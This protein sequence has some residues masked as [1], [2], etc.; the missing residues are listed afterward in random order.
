MLDVLQSSYPNEQIYLSVDE[1]H[2]NEI[3]KKIQL[4]T[5]TIKHKIFKYNHKEESKKYALLKTIREVC[6]A[7]SLFKLAKADRAKLIF[8][9]S[10]YPF[11]AIFLN[12][13]ST[14]FKQQIIICQHGD[15]GVLLL[16][17]DKITTKVFRCV[18]KNVLR[19]RNFKY[20]ISLF[21]G[22]TIKNNLYSLYPQYPNKNIITI[23]HP[24]E[25]NIIAF[26]SMLTYPVVIANIGTAI[27][28]KNS[29]L[30]FNLAEQ[31]KEAIGQK[32]I[33]IIQVG[34]MSSEVLAYSNQYVECL[35]N[36]KDFIKPEIFNGQ[37]MEADYFIY[38]FEKGG[39]YDLCP[40][41]TF[42]DAIKYNKPIV[43]LH[44]D[45]FDYYFSK[46]GNIGYLCDTIE[47]I[48]DIITSISKGEKVN[49]Y[50]IQV[51]NINNAKD[52]LS[53][54]EIANSFKGQLESIIDNINL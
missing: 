7:W 54:K 6:L 32:K 41:G 42:F 46:F 21:Y 43:A 30:I 15:L 12:L 50:P 31:V 33:K 48:A 2:L 10:A 18:I 53:I 1:I 40:S 35:Y 29:Q 4:K 52:R 27:L 22:L 36:G 47:E 44:N 28:A 23:D 39:Y 13:F 38:F 45:F 19:N 9:A 17:K 20:N 16:K 26:A 24:Y 11:T 14:I 5:H 34:R 37:L 8:F 25:F 49:E 51:A 3:S